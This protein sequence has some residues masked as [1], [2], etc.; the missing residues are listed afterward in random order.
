MKRENSCNRSSWMEKQKRTTN[1]KMNSF[2]F[3]RF[4]VLLHDAEGTRRERKL[5]VGKTTTIWLLKRE[6]VR[7][8]L[9]RG[10]G[11]YLLSRKNHS[12]VF[13]ARWRLSA[14][15]LCRIPAFISVIGPFI[16]FVSDKADGQRMLE[17]GWMFQK[18]CAHTNSAVQ[19]PVQW[20]SRDCF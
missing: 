3:L 20:R 10:G 13:Y 4:V 9:V 16:P 19:E 17:I 12:L 5:G 15:V 18:E 11:P 8:R 2:F 6:I 1:M 7:G 14:F